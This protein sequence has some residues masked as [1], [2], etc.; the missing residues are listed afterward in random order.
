MTKQMGKDEMKMIECNNFKCFKNL[1]R[2][3]D[4]LNCKTGKVF[5]I[6][7]N[8]GKRNYITSEFRRIDC[9]CG[10]GTIPCYNKSLF[11][12]VKTNECKI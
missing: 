2:K 10:A 4:C 3:L 6:C 11:I 12:G 5:V 7:F 1:N 8:C 9:S